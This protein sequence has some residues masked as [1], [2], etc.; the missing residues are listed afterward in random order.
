MDRF[1]DNSFFQD[2]K[3][4]TINEAKRLM[5]V[6]MTRPKEQLIL[7]TL[8]PKG[9]NESKN[10]PAQWLLDIGCDAIDAKAAAEV[11]NWGGADW[12]HIVKNDV[13][14][15]QENVVIEFTTLK[16]PTERQS[17]DSKLISPSKVKTNKQL[18]SAKQFG[19]FADRISATAADS[20]DSTVGDFI[21]HLMCLWDGDR[22]IIGKLAEAYGVKV[23]VEAVAA[24]IENFWAWMEQ[25]YGKYT[26]IERELPFS[27]T[28][29]LGQ[30]IT[31]EI[32]LVYH[33]AEG[34][35]LV[36]YKTYQGSVAHLTNKDSDFFAGKY[37]GQLALYEEALSRNGATIR[38]R[39][40]CYLSLGVIVKIEDYKA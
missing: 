17:F 1:E 6:G 12:I 20:C 27:F 31:G 11:I 26:H 32:D 33:T 9:K 4:A 40:I 22:S 28:N 24:S 25:T 21:H 5:Y 35:V 18:Y 16:Q 37:S 30:I 3:R 38:D 34:D 39:L 23:D 14:P 15:E 13:A 2:I 10:D 36:D 19:S 8:K 29:D 7:T